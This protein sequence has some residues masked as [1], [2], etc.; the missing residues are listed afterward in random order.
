MRK[1]L[2]VSSRQLAEGSVE[3]SQSSLPTAHCPLPTSSRGF[4]LIELVITLLVLT[5]LTMSVI[6]LI[7]VSVKRQ[8]EQ[9]LREA[10]HQIR[11]AINHFHREALA[12]AQMEPQPSMAGGSQNPNHNQMTDIG[13]I[14]N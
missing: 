6:P 12:V 3:N 13:W 11:T 8:R 1:K 10:L 9:Q 7:R 5:I 4:T 2:A 14:C